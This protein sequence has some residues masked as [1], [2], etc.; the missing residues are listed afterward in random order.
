MPDEEF[1]PLTDYPD[2]VLAEHF[3]VPVEQ[4]PEK[5]GDLGVRSSPGTSPPGR[6]STSTRSPDADTSG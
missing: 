6:R 5:R 4:I 3:N 2:V 1:A